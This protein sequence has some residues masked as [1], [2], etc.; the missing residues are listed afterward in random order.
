METNIILKEKKE[1]G[2]KQLGAGS[3]IHSYDMPTYEITLPE[4]VI[5]AIGVD[6]GDTINFFTDDTGRVYLEKA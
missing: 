4:V 3:K 1:A 6:P 5:N 2:R